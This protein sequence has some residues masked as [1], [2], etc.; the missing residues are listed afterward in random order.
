[1][2]K[3]KKYRSQ[4]KTIQHKNNWCPIIE[5]TKEDKDT[6]RNIA[7]EDIPQLR[8]TQI[9]WLKEHTVFQENVKEDTLR[10]SLFK[11][12]NL[13]DKEIILQAKKQVKK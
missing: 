2:K 11:L 13:K 10:H 5:D 3:A 4:K 9:L 12:L 6:F 7:Y 8:K 1:M